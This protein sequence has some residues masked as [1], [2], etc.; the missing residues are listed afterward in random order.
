MVLRPR[1]AASASAPVPADL[2]DRPGSAPAVLLARYSNAPC[3]ASMHWD[4][5]LRRGA[6]LALGHSHGRATARAVPHAAAT[7][8]AAVHTRGHWAATADYAAAGHTRRALRGATR[9]A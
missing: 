9:D 6:V 8:R 4:A 3:G 5:E 7:V 2:L 1:A